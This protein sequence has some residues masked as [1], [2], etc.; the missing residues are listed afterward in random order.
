M[1]AMGTIFG[2]LSLAAVHINASLCSSKA[3]KNIFA[4]KN[5]ETTTHHVSH[6]FKVITNAVLCRFYLRW[7]MIKLFQNFLL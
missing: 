5:I 6:S 3:F 2:D 7:E 4:T 1:E